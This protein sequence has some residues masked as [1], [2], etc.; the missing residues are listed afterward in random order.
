MALLLEAMKE[1]IGGY[2]GLQHTR[3]LEVEP[4]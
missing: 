2:G 1:R 3:G 4:K